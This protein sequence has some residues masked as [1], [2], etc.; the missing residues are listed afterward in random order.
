VNLRAGL[1]ERVSDDNSGRS[2]SIAQQNE[3]GRR[4]VAAN[5]WRIASTHSDAES[6]SRFARRGR[7][8]W[9][10]MRQDVRGNR[11][12]VVVLWEP[13][14][15]DRKNTAWSEFLDECRQQDVSV[16]ITSHQRLYDPGNARDR[17]SLLEDGVDSD[18]ESEKISARTRR[19]LADLAARGEPTGRIPYGYT[20]RYDPIT[21]QLLAQ[22][23]GEHATVVRDIITRTAQGESILAIRNY[24]HA[25]HIPSPS[26]Q[27]WWPRR[28]ITWIV[29]NGVVYIG[30]RR[31]NGGPLLDGNWQAIV[32]EETYWKAVQV[33]QGNVKGTRPGAARH[34]LSYIAR[35]R[36]GSPL[37]VQNRDGKPA[38]RC[39]NTK[40]GC[41]WA[42]VDWMDALITEAV[43]AFCSQESVYQGITA[44]D[45]SESVDSRDE[46]AAGLARLA[47]FEQQAI[48][49][50]ISPESFARIAKGIEARIAELESQSRKSAVPPAVRDLLGREEHVRAMWKGMPLPSQRRVIAALFAPELDPPGQLDPRSA[51]RVRL[52]KGT[53][54]RAGHGA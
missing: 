1:Y 16:Y 21:R 48:D 51:R 23:P 46:I 35:C 12:D 13:S 53:A 3:A 49:G 15:G 9:D 19:G 29:T 54:R 30:K 47:D 6:A 37:S 4:A 20:R 39:S 41:A 7:P 8:G 26:G 34:L 50:K 32:E 5:G 10:A 27:E 52:G 17:R 38:Y 25:R 36:C 42:P 28:S 14:R 2:R 44:E 22:E 18:Y 40:A 31:H 11:L 43:I 33:L 45:E 24:L